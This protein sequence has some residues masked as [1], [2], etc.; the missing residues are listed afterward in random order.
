[1]YQYGFLVFWMQQEGTVRKT[2]RDFLQMSAE[3]R[4]QELC[5]VPKFRVQ[6]RNRISWVLSFQRK[7]QKYRASMVSALRPE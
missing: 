6:P 4:V 3:E 7:N 1:M 5:R 2:S